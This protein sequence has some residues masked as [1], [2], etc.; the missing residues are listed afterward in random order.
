[1]SRKIKVQIGGEFERVRNF[2]YIKPL[3]ADG[4]ELSN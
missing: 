3:I 1:M 2:K 4:H